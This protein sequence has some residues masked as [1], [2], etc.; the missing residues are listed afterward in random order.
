[1]PS[2]AEELQRRHAEQEELICLSSDRETARQQLLSYQ[3]RLRLPDE[4]VLELGMDICR[5]LEQGSELVS[6][7]A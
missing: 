5:G 2:L 1:L 6:A 4:A 7:P 3:E